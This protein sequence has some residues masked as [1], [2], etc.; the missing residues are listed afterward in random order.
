MSFAMDPVP[1]PEPLSVNVQT[2]I[3]WNVLPDGARFSAIKGQIKGGGASNPHAT[4]YSLAKGYLSG[5]Y[6]KRGVLKAARRVRDRRKRKEVRFHLKNLI[7][8]VPRVSGVSRPLPPVRMR[9]S[10]EGLLQLKVSA[11]LFLQGDEDRFIGF[12]P[13][14]AP[15]NYSNARL[16]AQ[17]MRESVETSDEKRSLFIILDLKR[18]VSFQFD[19]DDLDNDTKDLR[20]F[21]SKIESDIKKARMH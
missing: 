7:R 1:E 2:S 9:Q 15:I 20:E 8:M 3:R 16:Y 13:N 6:D 10:P 5:R 17:L 14:E 18:A 21:F 12:W 11:Q 19:V 4:T